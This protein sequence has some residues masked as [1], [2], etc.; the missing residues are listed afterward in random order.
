MLKFNNYPP[1]AGELRLN[2][3]RVAALR[4]WANRGDYASIQA[5]GAAAGE[6]VR[7][8]ALLSTTNDFYVAGGAILTSVPDRF[9]EHVNFW[10]GF[11][12]AMPAGLP[13]EI[14]V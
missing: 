5:L 14:V 13:R 4:E 3:E 12:S 10:T 2:E 11:E 9:G 1:T 6:F 7:D 8:H